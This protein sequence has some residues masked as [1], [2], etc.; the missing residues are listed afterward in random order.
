M[1]K[2]VMAQSLREQG[3]RGS[4]RGFESDMCFNNDED[5]EQFERARR[6]SKNM[7]EEMVAAAGG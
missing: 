6:R 5:D 2:R 7:A 3:Q 4:D 1:S